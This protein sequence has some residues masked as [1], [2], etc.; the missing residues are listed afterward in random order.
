[1]KLLI[2]KDA[3]FCT[4]ESRDLSNTTSGSTIISVT[5]ICTKTAQNNKPVSMVLRNY[6]LIRIKYI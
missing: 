2:A 4:W 5:G 3:A 1:M 6:K